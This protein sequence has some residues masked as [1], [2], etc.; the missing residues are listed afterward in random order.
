MNYIKSTLKFK[1]NKVETPDLYLWEKSKKKYLGGKEVSTISSTKYIKSAVENVEEQLR[2][3]GERLPSR[4]V[5]PM[6]QWYNPET[7]SYPKLDRDGITTLQELIGIL[8]WELENG[9]VYILR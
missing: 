7:D 4:A 5:T 3:K 8:R 6:F 9:R 1:K 2:K